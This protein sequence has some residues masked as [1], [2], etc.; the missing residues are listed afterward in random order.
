MHAQT[1]QKQSDYGVRLR[2]KQKVKRIYGV[3]E[4]QFRNY[5]EKASK[6][7]GV[8]GTVLLT[9]LECRLDNVIYRMGIV[10]SR[11]QGRQ[12]VS[13]GH[14]NVN[15]RKIDV[16]SYQVQVGDV[17]TINGS[18]SMREKFKAAYEQNKDI[19]KVSWL[20]V[21]TAQWQAKVV[22]L[23]QRSDIQMPIQEQLIIELYSK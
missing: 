14:V 19:D 17:V 8:T 1:R 22:K 4:R 11:R 20:E 12:S 18:E 23:P 9:M 16:P 15:G 5:Y 13:H 6:A 21:D 2:E 3:L 7:K 10:N